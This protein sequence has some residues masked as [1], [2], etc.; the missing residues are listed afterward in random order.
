[1]DRRIP[2]EV[3]QRAEGCLRLS[4][5][6]EKGQAASRG[7]HAGGSG[8]DGG[9]LFY[10]AQGDDVELRWGK[11][12]GAGGL[13]IDVGQCKGAGDLAEEGGLF[14]VGLNQ[15]EG[16]LRGP[17][18][19]R[20]AG[21]S[22]AGADVGDAVSRD[23]ILNHPSWVRAGGGHRGHRAHAQGRHRGDAREQVTGGEEGFAKVARHDVFGIADGGEVDAGI[24][25][26]E[27]IDVCRYMLEL[28]GRQK[29]RLLTLARGGMILV[30][31]TGQ[32]KEWFEQFG[33]AARVHGEKF[34]T[35]DS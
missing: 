1:L 23:E 7:D 26:Q 31:S 16:D 28:R 35:A 4:G 14:E 34:L 11:G 13:Y 25:A 9:E 29:S 19:E 30:W 10:G 5:A 27:Y 12:F 21:E 8:E 18:F 22:G 17:E 6:D 3:R 2:G 32:A 15:S 20:E 24:P 33:D